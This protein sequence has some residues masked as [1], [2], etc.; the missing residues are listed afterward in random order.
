VL[1]TTGPDGSAVLTPIWYLYKGGVILMRTSTDSIKALNLARDP[2]ATVCV[3]EERPPYKSVTLYGEAKIGEVE[4]K[5]GSQMAHHY[6]GAVGAVA[7]QRLAEANV[8]RGP[9]ATV[10]FT[11][12]RVLTQDFSLETPLVGKVWLF[13]KRV[14]PP[15]L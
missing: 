11:P 15:W 12:S 7:Y 14:L 4:P 5:L 8:Q 13:V 10:T 1:A 3:Q 2:R 6:L 9:E